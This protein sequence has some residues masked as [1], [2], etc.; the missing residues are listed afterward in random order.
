MVQALRGRSVASC[1]TALLCVHI[2]AIQTVS[3]PYELSLTRLLTE[4]RS[5]PKTYHSTE[6]ATRFQSEYQHFQDENETRIMYLP[7]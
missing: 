6:I 5:P 1:F 3:Q 4:E 2:L 7:A